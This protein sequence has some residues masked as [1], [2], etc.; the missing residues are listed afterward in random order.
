MRDSL[1]FLILAAG[2]LGV[3]AAIVS[4]GQQSETLGIEQVKDGLYMINGTGGNVCVR[5]SSE[6]VILVDDKF[7][8]N[9]E[10]IQAQVQSVT[11]SPV[12]YVLNTHHHGD[13]SG[14][15]VEYIEIAEIIA[16]QNAR[17]NMVRGD[18]PAPP[19]VV[20]TNETAVYLGGVEVRA[21]HFGRGHTNG[22][23]VVYFPDLRTVH[24]GDLLHGIAPFRPDLERPS[25]PVASRVFKT[26]ERRDAMLAGA[27]WGPWREHPPSLRGLNLDLP[28]NALVA[29]RRHEQGPVQEGMV[30]RH[31]KRHDQRVAG[32][33][34]RHSHLP[35]AGVDRAILRRPN[36]ERAIERLDQRR[37]C[38]VCPPPVDHE[39]VGLPLGNRPSHL[40]VGQ[41]PPLDPSGVKQDGIPCPVLV[42]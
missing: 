13:H 18:Q 41:D 28:V 16:H 34:D 22:D 24:G 39:C 27:P 26:R 12:R 15:N 23:A 6:G 11:D 30:E 33:G 35:P 5:V 3:G 8:R 40:L 4:T 17:D 1:R 9:F 37:A 2:A 7:P 21:Y 25:N 14:G 42:P 31:R 32:P 29:I 19:R 20:F 36:L 38:C 10:A